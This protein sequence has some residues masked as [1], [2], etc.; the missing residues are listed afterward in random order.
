M[1]TLTL[2]LIVDL[3]NNKAINLRKSYK[4]LDEHFGISK[5]IDKLGLHQNYCTQTIQRGENKGKICM[6][7]SKDCNGYCK[8]HYKSVLKRQSKV[9]TGIL[10]D[11]EEP[12]VYPTAPSFEDIEID[13]IYIS[14]A[15][16]T[17]DEYDPYLIALPEQNEEEI[18][19]LKPKKKKKKKNNKQVTQIIDIKQPFEF[20]KET[21]KVQDKISYQG[22]LFNDYKLQNYDKEIIE[23]VNNYQFMILNENNED[24]SQYFKRLDE[25][26]YQDIQGF[27]GIKIRSMATKVMEINATGYIKCFNKSKNLFWLYH[28]KYMK[29]IVQRIKF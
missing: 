6:Y 5:I 13:P 3:Y 27:Q 25:I 26:H 9:P 22:Y 10:I 8:N 23:F 29:N 17:S 20:K 21:I 16:E 12:V 15:K 19:E 24:L 1:N 7:K 28:S 14:L 18:K 4:T 11:I 2:G